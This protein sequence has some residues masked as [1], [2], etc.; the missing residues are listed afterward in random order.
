VGNF[1]NLEKPSYTPMVADATLSNNKTDFTNV[2]GGSAVPHRAPHL[3]SD[4]LL[5]AGG[6]VAY[7]DGHAVWRT[8]P[9]QV[10][11]RVRQN[12]LHWW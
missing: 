11:M 1:E 10:K 9:E 3:E 8:F 4:T 12:P 6:N 5:P 2:R 7:A